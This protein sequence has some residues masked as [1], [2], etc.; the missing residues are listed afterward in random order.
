M[1]SWLFV[2]ISDSVL[3]FYSDIDG[4]YQ[5]AMKLFD[6]EAVYQQCVSLSELI[7][8]I[9]LAPDN[10]CFVVPKKSQAIF[11]INLPSIQEKV[12]H[13]N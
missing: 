8:S 13:A 11:K 7:S 4:I 9:V 5:N 3:L 6:E 10:C 2:H 1:Y 12:H